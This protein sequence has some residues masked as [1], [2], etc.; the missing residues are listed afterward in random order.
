MNT[1]P[2][3]KQLLLAATFGLVATTPF[4]TQ[5]VTVTPVG[6]TVS[7]PPSVGFVPVVDETGAQLIDGK[8]G[9]DSWL[10]DLGN[11]AG[12]EW[13]GWKEN[14]PAITFDFGASILVES[15]QIGLCRDEDFGLI[16]MPIKVQVWVE[17]DFAATLVQFPVVADAISEDTRGWLT[18][19]GSWTGQKLTVGLI[20]NNYP[21]I[22]VDEVKFANSQS[23]GVPDAS[24]SLGL[25]TLG[26]AT[27]GFFRRAGRSA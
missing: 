15:L 6:Y 5:A 14:S 2:T 20:W 7:P 11:G 9:A 18:F 27:L 17:G 16:G 23:T 25:M 19:N 12:Y 3:L 10:T 26:L 8:L 21:W 24:S 13:V 4:D 1:S 22:L